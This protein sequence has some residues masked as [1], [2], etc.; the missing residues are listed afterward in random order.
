MNNEQEEIVANFINGNLSSIRRLIENGD[1]VE[2]AKMV[3]GVYQDLAATAQH[4]WISFV[5]S[6]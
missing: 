3:I 5:E 6:L 2:M 4:R 1:P